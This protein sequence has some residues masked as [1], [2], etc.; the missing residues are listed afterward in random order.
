MTEL[1]LLTFDSLLRE[2]MEEL[3]ADDVTQAELAVDPIERLRFKAKQAVLA[4]HEGP[5]VRSG[6]AAY[7]E[8]ME[9]PVTPP[10]KR[11]LNLLH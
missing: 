10:G 7:V 2:K 6:H 9:A 3:D 8:S 5:M 4:D 11:H 1:G